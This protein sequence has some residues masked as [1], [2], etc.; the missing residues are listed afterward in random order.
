MKTAFTKKDLAVALICVLFL[1]MNF[2][3]IGD[4][5]RKR[6]KEMV[7]LSN[8]N[9]WGHIFS[10]YTEAND[11]KFWTGVY[12]TGYWWPWQLEEQYKDW[13]QNKTWFCPNATTPTVDEKGNISPTLNIFN[14][15]G[16]Y[17]GE[18]GGYSSGPNGIAGS[19]GLNGY[20]LN[21]PINTT[22]DRGISAKN[23]WRTTNVDGASNIPLFIDALRFDLW[24]W[25]E[26]APASNE[27]AAWTSTGH[28]ARCCINRHN[29][30]VN[31]LFLDFSARKVGLK[32]LWISKWH[33]TFNTEGPWTMAGG[34]WPSDWP[35]WMRNFKD[36]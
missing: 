19:Y 4:S 23:G 27:Y 6:A 25:P 34:V 5:G 14:A 1:L 30:A 16:I 36:Y 24:P 22:F 7:C 9:Q 31:C 20:V 3:A 33:R 21:I 32:E 18:Q 29:G 8:L 35:E 12:S 13:K 28:M 11:G 17:K 15:W 10:M 2:G 26:D